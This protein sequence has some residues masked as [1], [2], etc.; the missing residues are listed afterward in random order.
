M[1]EEIV[2][3]NGLTSSVI[4]QQAILSEAPPRMKSSAS[5]SRRLE[6]DFLADDF[7]NPFDEGGWR[8]CGIEDGEE[9]AAG[10]GHEGG[11]DAG[12]LAQ[13]LF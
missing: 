12:L 1:V 9:R 8:F 5:E 2:R 11:A 10:A 4:V 3:E 6:P 7:M 13:P